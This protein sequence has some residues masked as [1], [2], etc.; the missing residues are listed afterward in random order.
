MWLYKKKLL[1][2]KCVVAFLGE[3]W[4][5]QNQGM[6]PAVLPTGRNFGCKTQKWLEKCVVKFF[7]KIPVYQKRADKEVELFGNILIFI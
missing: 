7:L 2:K 4:R 3:F 1:P 6:A 5:R